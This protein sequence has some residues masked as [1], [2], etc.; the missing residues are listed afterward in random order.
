MANNDK[1]YNHNAQTGEILVRE[2]TD[3]EQAVHD[4]LIAEQI[5]AEESRIAAKLAA[6][7]KLQALGLTTEDLQALGL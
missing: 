7:S 5:L 3:D 2:F 6:Q 4:A 1:E